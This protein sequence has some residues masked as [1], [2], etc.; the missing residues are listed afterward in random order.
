LSEV[1]KLVVSAIGYKVIRIGSMPIGR[2]DK[3]MGILCN[4]TVFRLLG[5]GEYL[6]APGVRSWTILAFDAKPH[7]LG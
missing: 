3:P 1:E 2:E 6:K 4:V 5:R 7:P